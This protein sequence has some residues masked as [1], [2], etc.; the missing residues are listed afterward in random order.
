MLQYPRHP[1]T[2]VVDSGIYPM[3][4]PGFPDSISAAWEVKGGRGE[5]GRWG[6]EYERGVRG[7]MMG[8]PHKSR[9]GFFI[10]GIDTSSGSG[11]DNTGATFSSSSPPQG[12]L[13]IRANTRYFAICRIVI[14]RILR[15]HLRGRLGE[16]RQSRGG[17]GGKAGEGSMTA[18]RHERGSP[19]DR[20]T[21]GISYL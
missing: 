21:G 18:A 10:I 15:R 8:S 4:F 19:L 6:G 20:V 11:N 13:D 12:C 7:G 16:E 17:R 1:P 5:K 3:N 14:T 2:A 9:Y